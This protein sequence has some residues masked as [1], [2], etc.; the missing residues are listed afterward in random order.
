MLR[1]GP[2]G[3]SVDTYHGLVKVHRARSKPGGD[4][5]V[6]NI[7]SICGMA[8]ILPVFPSRGEESESWVVNS[9]IDLT[10]FNGIY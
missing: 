5:A 2:E 1:P 7:S 9:R 10:T 3:G 4:F 6:T 8:Y